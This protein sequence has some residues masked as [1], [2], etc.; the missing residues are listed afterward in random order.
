MELKCYR[1]ILRI[2]WTQKRT[3]RSILEELGITENWLLKTIKN[4]KLTY[5]GHIK[6]HQSLERTIFEGK[7][8]NNRGRGR[9]KRRWSDD[10]EGDLDTDL[11]TAGRMAEERDLYRRAVMKAT[12]L[13][14]HAT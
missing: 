11:T 4:K 3:N 2:S 6:R 12:F 1:H 13:R 10:I 9:P 5:F 7:M 8:P 14:E